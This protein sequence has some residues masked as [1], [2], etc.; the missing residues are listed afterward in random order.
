MSNT[1]SWNRE[2]VL[3]KPDPF[4]PLSL[5]C[6]IALPFSWGG[7]GMGKFKPSLDVWITKEVFQLAY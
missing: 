7:G 2:Y 1:V 4:F 3:L 5:V 6:F